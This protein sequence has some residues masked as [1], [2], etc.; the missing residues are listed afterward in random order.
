M[1]QMIVKVSIDLLN[2]VVCDKQLIVKSR[3]FWFDLNEAKKYLHNA[4]SKL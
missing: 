1:R 4:I 3:F 2:I